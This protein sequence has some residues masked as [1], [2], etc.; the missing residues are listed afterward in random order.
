VRV[1]Y[2]IDGL[3]VGGT[4][5]SLADIVV[6]LRA[7]KPVV[8]RLFDR[9]A[10]E[11]ELHAAGVDTV[12]LDVDRRWAFPR[13]ARALRKVMQRRGID[14]VHSMLFSSNVLAR[15][16]GA[17]LATPVV[18]T[19]VSESYS[20]ARLRTMSRGRRFKHRFVRDIDRRTSGYAARFIANSESVKRSACQALGLS[21]SLVDVIP[22]GRDPS[23]FRVPR[24]VGRKLLR[25]VTGWATD[26]RV[27][28]N[29]GRLVTGK[30]HG[31]LFDAFAILSRQD[32][33]AR[34]LLVGDGPERA[35]IETLARSTGLGSSIFFA[36]TSNRVPE[37]LAASDVFAFPSE[38]EGMPGAVIEAMMAGVPVVASDI[39]VHHELI[40]DGETGF[41]AD[42]RDAGSFARTLADAFSDAGKRMAAVGRAVAID[43]FSIDSVV[44]RH[45]ETYAMLRPGARG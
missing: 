36:G 32:P 23:L 35:N 43:R 6:R 2:L 31:S 30:G 39:D 29:V 40:D 11:P 38:Y 26:A 33:R 21:T 20:P 5:K 45:E 41:I 34:L 42:V 14:L 4:E 22:R 15:L 19:I 10:L 12:N 7:T 28:I 37:L 1:L 9:T 27:V 18:N 25:D 17:S 8:C 3:G 24:D 13:A 16:V 44:R